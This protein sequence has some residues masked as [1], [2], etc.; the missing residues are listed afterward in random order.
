MKKRIAFVLLALL[1]A[2]SFAACTTDP[3]TAIIGTWECQDDTQPHIYWCN[4]T[5]EEGGRFF[6]GD[7]DWGN[8]H[9]FEDTLTLDYDNWGQITFS[10]SIRGRLLTI[11][12]DETHIVLTRQ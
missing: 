2:A 4:L 11:I 8:F 12:G 10:F 7:G 1:L 9:I 3:E 5:F 6:D